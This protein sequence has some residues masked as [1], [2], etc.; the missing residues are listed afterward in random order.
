MGAAP[1]HSTPNHFPA[2]VKNFLML[3]AMGLDPL[4][5]NGG[6]GSHVSI[7]FHVGNS[8]RERCSCDRLLPYLGLGEI[9]QCFSEGGKAVR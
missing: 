4:G 6:W 1:S 5:L 3:F 9:L 2:Y 7:E 8:L